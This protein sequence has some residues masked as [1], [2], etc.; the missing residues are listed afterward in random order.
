MALTDQ[1]IMP[2]RD[3]QSIT[4]EVRRLTGSSGT[5]TSGEVVSELSTVVKMPLT[6]IDTVTVDDG[7][8]SVTSSQYYRTLV[9]FREGSTGM[10]VAFTKGYSL[11]G[12]AGISQF[13]SSGSLEVSNSAFVCKTGYTYVWNVSESSSS[14]WY[15]ATYRVYGYA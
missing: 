7:V 10:L 5:L 6:L 4:D 2:G 15:E 11:S 12:V 1:V 14:V 3:Y 8:I 9:A 13:V